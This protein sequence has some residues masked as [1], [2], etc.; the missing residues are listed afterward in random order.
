[1]EHLCTKTGESVK[2]M[3]TTND[4]QSHF[5]RHAIK[6]RKFG[7]VLVYYPLAHVS[8]N[9]EKFNIEFHRPIQIGLYGYIKAVVL[10]HKEHKFYRFNLF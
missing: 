5:A 8:R 1:M 4:H 10:L 6:I 9:L 2:V 3:L 7:N